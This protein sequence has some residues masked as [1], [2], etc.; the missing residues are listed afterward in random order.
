LMVPIREA[1][2][3]APELAQA[4]AV[5]LRWASMTTCGRCRVGMEHTARLLRQALARAGGA[6][7]PACS[8]INHDH[9]CDGSCP[10]G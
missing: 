7:Y 10:L 5:P 2:T 1:V 4:A 6:T 3:T 9:V 8:C